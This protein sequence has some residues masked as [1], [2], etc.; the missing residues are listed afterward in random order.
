MTQQ[1][2]YF[3]EAAGYLNRALGKGKWVG[4][5]EQGILQHVKQIR[6]HLLMPTVRVDIAFLAEL[7]PIS[8]YIY[9]CFQ[10]EG[11]YRCFH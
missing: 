2:A 6:D 4:G 7:K 5:D 8:E 3:L 1:R 11:G 9:N 10:E